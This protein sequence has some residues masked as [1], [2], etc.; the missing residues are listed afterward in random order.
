[1]QN[2]HRT[3]Q[4]ALKK[5]L[6]PQ[7][8]WLERSFPSIRRVAD[9]VWPAQKTIFEVQYSPISAKE[10]QA[11]NRDYQKMGYTVIWILHDRHFNRT[12]LTPAERCL[13]SQSHYFTNINAFGHGEIYDQ[14]AHIQWGRRV[15]RTPR[16]P[17]SIK[18]LT[19]LK[20]I[21]RHFPVDRRKW[22]LSF[23]GDLF[24]QN[25]QP[26]KV[27]RLRLYRLLFQLVLEKTCH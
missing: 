27:P 22:T 10:V 7:E 12:Y 18:E 8:V 6:A 11:R 15:K 19:H 26:I 14:Y 24:H 3:I 21:P 2:S 20:S 4:L 17:I 23:G 16:Y 13:R 1:M 9:V 25:Y 5:A